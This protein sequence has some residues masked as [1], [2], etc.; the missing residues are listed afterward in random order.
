MK[1]DSLPFWTASLVNMLNK[2]AD[3]F[4]CSNVRPSVRLASSSSL[5]SACCPMAIVC[6]V[7]PVSCEY[8]VICKFINKWSVV[9]LKN[10]RT[11]SHCEVENILLTEEPNFGQVIWL[12]MI[13]LLVV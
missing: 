10:W 6:I 5:S 12:L 3:S 4:L 2:A 9:Q 13:C 7:I 11:V 1:K 8:A